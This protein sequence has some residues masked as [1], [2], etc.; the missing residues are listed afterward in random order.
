MAEH[1]GDR[2]AVPF[3]AVDVGLYFAKR[4]GSLGVL[5]VAMEHR[6]L[7]VLPSLIGK[8]LLGLAVVFDETVAVAIAVGIAPRKTGRRIRPHRPHGFEV[9]GARKIFAEQQHEKLSRIHAPV[10]PAEWHLA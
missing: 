2:R 4:D 6:V 5:A 1:R 3:R 7:G 9:A 8:P 10:I